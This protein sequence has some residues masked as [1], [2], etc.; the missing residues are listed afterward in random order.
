MIALVL[1]FHESIYSIA[2]TVVHYGM[3][4]GLVL[5]EA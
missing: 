5:F 3:A 4:G 2:L 1:L